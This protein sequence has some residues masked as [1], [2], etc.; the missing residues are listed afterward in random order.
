MICNV[1]KIDRLVRGLLAVVL[2][3]TALYFVP[4]MVPKTL[5]L[6]VAV[7]LLLSAWFG[8]C[9]I[10]RFLGLNSSPKALDAKTIPLNDVRT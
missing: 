9:F 3:A 8:V 4:T 2:I 1:G 5:L 7:L 10:Y 6:T